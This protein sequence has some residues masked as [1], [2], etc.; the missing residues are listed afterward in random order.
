MASV[1]C[2]LGVNAA[3][4]GFILKFKRENKYGVIESRMEIY[5]FPMHWDGLTMLNFSKGEKL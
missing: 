3:K 4:V 2:S 5:A 1:Q